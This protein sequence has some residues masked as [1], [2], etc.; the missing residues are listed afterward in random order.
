MRKASYGALFLFAS[1]CFAQV[2]LDKQT[3][4]SLDVSG[5]DQQN[6]T[7]TKVVL[8]QGVTKAVRIYSE[9]SHTLLGV[10]VDSTSMPNPTQTDWW[11]TTVGALPP[12]AQL[13]RLPM[14]EGRSVG[15]QTLL[16]PSS[17]RDLEIY[18]WGIWP[19]GEEKDELLVHFSGPRAF[20]FTVRTGLDPAT[21]RPFF[22]GRCGDGSGGCGG[23]CTDCKPNDTLWCCER[24]DS[25]C[26]GRAPG[27]TRSVLPA[28]SAN[29]RS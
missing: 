4:M 15:L 7:I 12:R 19:G 28:H 24:D 6:S 20:Q 27:F 21:M 26:G 8:G 17:D 10:I 14:V 5:Y 13:A 18:V 25:G 9:P 22:H 2:D 23:S 29:S 1:T 16:R 11:R 3:S